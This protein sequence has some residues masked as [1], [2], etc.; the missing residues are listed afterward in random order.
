MSQRTFVP[1]FENTPPF[2]D[3][4][5]SPTQPLD[6]ALE[7]TGLLGVNGFLDLFLIRLIRS[8]R[9]AA[10]FSRRIEGRTCLSTLPVGEG[11]EESFERVALAFDPNQDTPRGSTT[12]FLTTRHIGAV[13]TRGMGTRARAHV[14]RMPRDR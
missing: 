13:T 6:T 2:G 8:P 3:C 9:V 1:P 11:L 5:F 7:K 14:W 10:L 12:L 4:R